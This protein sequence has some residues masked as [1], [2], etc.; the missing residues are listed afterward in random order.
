MPAWHYRL[1]G[2]EWADTVASSWQIRCADCELARTS[3]AP[4]LSAV[5]VVFCYFPENRW[6]FSSIIHFKIVY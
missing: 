3:S 4:L 5:V 6:Y 2:D 1:T